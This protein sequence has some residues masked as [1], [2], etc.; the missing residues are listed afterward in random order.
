ML[1]YKN[2]NRASNGR[3]W[4]IEIGKAEKEFS[5]NVCPT[6]RWAEIYYKNICEIKKKR[7]GK[8]QEM[9]NEEMT[10]EQSFMQFETI[11]T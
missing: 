6:G 10:F 2:S 11:R 8:L 3:I 4:I 5:Y 1:Y 7:K 9:E